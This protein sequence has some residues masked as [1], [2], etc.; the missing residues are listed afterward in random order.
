MTPACQ[1]PRRFSLIESQHST[2]GRVRSVVRNRGRWEKSSMVVVR[3]FTN[4]VDAEM[5]MAILE[6]AGIDSAMRRDENPGAQPGTGPTGGIQ[7]V[8]AEQDLA[9][10]TEVLDAEGS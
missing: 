7:V 8:V 4:R 10:A 5:A 9:T 6:V 2:R 3:A 1:A